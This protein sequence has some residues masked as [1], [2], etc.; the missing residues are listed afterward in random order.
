MFQCKEWRNTSCYR[1]EHSRV[2]EI[3]LEA[4]CREEVHEKQGETGLWRVGKEG[5][6]AACAGWHGRA[7]AGGMF[8]L[9]VGRH[10]GSDG[11]TGVASLRRKMG[12]DVWVLF[13]LSLVM[14]CGCSGV[15]GDCPSS[16]RESWC[17][18]GSWFASSVRTTLALS[19][20]QGTSGEGGGC[21]GH[22]SWLMETLGSGISL[23][24]LHPQFLQ[25]FLVFSICPWLS[26]TQQTLRRDRFP[27]PTLAVV[28][29]LKKQ[30]AEVFISGMKKFE[31]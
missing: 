24:M 20:G 21:C 17:Q 8:Q 13:R 31:D 3:P 25:P 9:R 16:Q 10:G 5:A 6:G 11:S 19:K 27:R 15:K 29:L 14:L 26:L 23:T 12:L 18:Q 30:T 2:S 4:V 28:S 7:G 1:R 22:L